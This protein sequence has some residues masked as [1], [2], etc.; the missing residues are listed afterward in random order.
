VR[1]GVSPPIGFPLEAVIQV[2]VDVLGPVPAPTVAAV[3]E[4]WCGARV[5]LVPVLDLFGVLVIV[6]I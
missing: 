5:V 6:R 3:A 2:V 4:S 1:P